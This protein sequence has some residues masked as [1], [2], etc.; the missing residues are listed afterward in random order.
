MI[1]GEIACDKNR[2]FLSPGGYPERSRSNT[3]YAAGAPIKVHG[4]V[5]CHS[6]R[7][8]I[9]VPHR[10]AVRDHELSLIREQVD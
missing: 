5:P 10:E 9:Q 2:R 4:D 3:I 6:W 7:E 8:P 1:E